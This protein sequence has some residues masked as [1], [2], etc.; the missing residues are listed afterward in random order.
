M[1]PV[2]ALS[3]TDDSVMKYFIH[4]EGRTSYQ[5]T[6]GV[7]LHSVDAAREIATR[8]IG[9]MVRDGHPH[10]WGSQPWTLTVTDQS[11]LILFTISVH[12]T[13]APALMGLLP[14]PR[15]KPT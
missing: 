6:D 3:F 10:L 11:G 14:H 8:T 15:L 4:S 2:S 9:E 1:L 12:A 7:E 13:D 5:D